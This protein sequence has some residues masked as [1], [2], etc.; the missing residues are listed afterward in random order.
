MSIEEYHQI[1]WN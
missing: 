1:T